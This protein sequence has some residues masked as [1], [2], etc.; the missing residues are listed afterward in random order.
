MYHQMRMDEYL[1]FTVTVY[2]AMAQWGASC[3]TAGLSC[4][5]LFAVG[6]SGRGGV[7]PCSFAHQRVG[8]FQT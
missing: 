3:R 6:G 7:G 4:G 1:E 5:K 8:P 2:G